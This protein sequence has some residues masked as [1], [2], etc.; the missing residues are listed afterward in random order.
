M[1]DRRLLTLKRVITWLAWGG[2]VSTYLVLLL[3]P[4][5]VPNDY[6]LLALVLVFVLVL[7]SIVCAIVLLVRYR[8]VFGQWHSIAV[9]VIAL[10]LGRWL[11]AR[12]LLSGSVELA[13]S[14]LTIDVM[15]ALGVCLALVLWKRDN[16]LQLMGWVSVLAIWIVLIAGRVQGNILELL[17]SSLGATDYYPLWWLDSLWCLLW[18]SIPLGALSFLWHIVKLMRKEIQGL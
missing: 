18:W 4:T 3:L 9:L 8:Q 11:T 17:L 2:F 7:I 15:I 1:A 14:V 5:N 12:S 6:L 10:T 13:V 16:G